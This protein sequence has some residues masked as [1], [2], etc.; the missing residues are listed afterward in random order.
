M[1]AELADRLRRLMRS[2]PDVTERRMFG[3]LAFLVGGHMAVTASR[4]GGV[5]VRVD[6]EQADG[7]VGPGVEV[8]V[9]KGRPMRGWLH[10]DADSVPTDDD[11]GV[12][13]DRALGWVATL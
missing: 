4:R 5:M 10:V 1:N 11:L 6:P 7:W 2:T 9:M 3:G 8:V 12:W 13:V